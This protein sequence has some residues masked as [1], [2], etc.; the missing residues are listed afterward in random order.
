[1][2]TT[3]PQLADS[4]LRTAQ[5][6]L[7]EWN[8]SATHIELVSH[9]ENIV[10]RVHGDDGVGYALRLHRPGYH[11]LEELNSEQQWTAA[12]AA[13]GIDVP[14]AIALPAGGGYYACVDVPETKEQRYVGLVGWL[15]GELLSRKLKA[16]TSNAALLRY[17]QELGGIAGRIH[18]QAVVWRIP[19]KFSRHQLNAEGLL[20]EQPFWGPFWNLPHFSRAESKLIRKT[21]AAIYDSLVAYKERSANSGNDSMYSMIHAD[22][23]H[24]NLLVDGDALHI[25]DFDDA[26]FGWHLYE[27]AVALFSFQESK[28][29]N[30]VRDA[31]LVGYRSQREISN[32][33]IALIPMFLLIRGLALLGWM[34]H[35]PELN[36]IESLQHLTQL[37]CRQADTTPW[38]VP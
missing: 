28:N 3:T 34:H 23:H 33:D 2:D 13:A 16:Q 5:S 38:V 37:V 17:I 21:R 18:N 11:N 32:S 25:I 20:G 10:Y 30:S 6:A 12:L 7:T 29:Y 31:L 14:R 1:M 24:G 35:R 19:E 15:D 26:G 22:L 27:L 36:R 8:L 9:S 4:Y